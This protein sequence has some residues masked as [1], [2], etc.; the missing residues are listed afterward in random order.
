[1]AEATNINTSAV[2]VRPAGHI[3][4]L[5]MDDAPPQPPVFAFNGAVARYGVAILCVGA[6]LAARK[7][8]SPLLGPQ[9][10]YL[11][12]F[13]AVVFASWYCG[14]GP[15]ILSVV[16]AA[17]GSVYYFVPPA[18]SF[19]IHERQDVWALLGFLFFASLI[20]LMGEA[21]R[22]SIA[23]RE[24][25][26]DE[27]SEMRELL[28]QR[29]QQRT[30]DLQKKT[31]EVTHQAKLLDSA[32]DAIRE[33]LASMAGKSMRFWVNLFTIFCRQSS[34]SPSPTFSPPRETRGRANSAIASA[35]AAM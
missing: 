9:D 11:T 33:R 18:H 6:S 20:V 34:Q 32:N 2:S 19:T 10:T 13:A 3:L 1:M 23:R 16:L 12:A 5:A 30:E 4:R 8:L 35:T 17:I 26:E 25:A 7:L 29:I 22:H 21:N 27:A 28:E 31:A 14:L 15:A 24:A